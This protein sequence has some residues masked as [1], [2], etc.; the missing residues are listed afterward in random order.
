MDAYSTFHDQ[1]VPYIFD[2]TPT[3]PKIYGQF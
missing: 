2:L 1:T 3:F